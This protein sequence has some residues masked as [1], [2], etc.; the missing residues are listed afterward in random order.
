M[1]V[2][3]TIMVSCSLEVVVPPPA[4]FSSSPPS[5]FLPPS[6]SLPVAG[7]TG[8]TYPLPLEIVLSSYV[9]KLEIVLG[10]YVISL[11]SFK[12]IVMYYSYIN[13]MSCF[14]LFVFLFLFCIFI[15]FNFMN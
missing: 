5:S 13:K 2:I 3:L 12:I 6:S 14:Y 8:I 11:K 7:A 9:T 4:L 10:S 15:C 1:G